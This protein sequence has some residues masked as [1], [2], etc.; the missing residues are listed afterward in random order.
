MPDGLQAPLLK[1]LA[2]CYSATG[3]YVGCFVIYGVHMMHK[4]N[5]LSFSVLG[6]LLV[7]GCGRSA[8]NTE[9]S[10]AQPSVATT[11]VKFE[12]KGFE[13]KPCTLEVDQKPDGSLKSLKF[14]EDFKVDYKMPAP[15]SGLYG[16]YYWPKTFDTAVNLV[17]SSL[18][19][20]RSLLG[21]ADV[22]EGDGK[23]LFWDA[24]TLHHKFVFKPSLKAPKKVTYHSV[25]RVAGVVPFVVIDGEC[26]F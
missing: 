3:C 13:N 20:K 5:H 18:T 26:N 8:P 10:A 22:L 4:I 6:L 21:D 19:V 2:V 23:P 7:F 24:G 1:Q 12:G 25:N 15:G 9:L 11:A 14:S 16:V 17:D